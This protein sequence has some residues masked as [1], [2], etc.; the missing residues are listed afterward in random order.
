MSIKGR[1]TNS[2]KNSLQNEMKSG[3]LNDSIS[4][5]KNSLIKL[6]PFSPQ[7]FTHD[8]APSEE[9]KL[10]NENHGTQ[11]DLAFVRGYPDG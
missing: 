9:E 2:N 10:R 3:L 5:F 1:A 11:I 6:S 7:I 4:A 8:F